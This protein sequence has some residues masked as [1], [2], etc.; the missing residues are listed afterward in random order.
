MS[1]K[2]GRLHRVW[3]GLQVIHSHMHNSQKTFAEEFPLLYED[4]YRYLAFRIPNRA[5]AEDVV[6]KTALLA[7]EKFDQYD[8]VRGTVAEWVM[9]IAKN[10]VRMYWRSHTPSCSLEE[11][12]NLFADTGTSHDDRL[13]HQHLVEQVFAA[14]N[15][16]QKALLALHYLDGVSYDVLARQFQ[17]SS[18][19]L[20]KK[21]SRT[22]ATI[23]GQFAYLV[24]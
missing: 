24:E 19:S 16:E 9:G 5:D 6:S 11:V 22:M 20:R 2:V 1:Q 12:E 15:D 14:L 10:Q 18:T 8:S 21:V 13:H 4:L 17:K 3:V 7:W 23:R